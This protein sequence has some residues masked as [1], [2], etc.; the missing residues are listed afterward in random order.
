MNPSPEAVLDALLDPGWM[1]RR[2]DVVQFGSESLLRRT[3]SF[4]FEIPAGLLRHQNNRDVALVPLGFW[5]KAPGKYSNIDFEDEQGMSL[6]LS[7]S[8][9]DEWLTL[10]VLL[11]YATRLLG[12]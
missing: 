7:T 6:P 2:K 1:I 12:R 9:Q 8:S 3:H 5:W 10:Q 11:K 4:D